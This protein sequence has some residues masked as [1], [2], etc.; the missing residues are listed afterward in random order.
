MAG[1]APRTEEMLELVKKAVE[2]DTMCP[3]DRV[4]KMAMIVQQ[5]EPFIESL[6]EA[7][8][9]PKPPWSGSESRSIIVRLSAMIRLGS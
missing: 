1:D 8:R 3:G 9:R 5:I 2:S 6:R 7:G 4:Q